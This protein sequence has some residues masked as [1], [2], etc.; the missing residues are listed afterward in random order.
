MTDTQAAV[1]PATTKT[2]TV[3]GDRVPRKLAALAGDGG[4]DVVELQLIG[5]DT[6]VRVRVV[7]GTVQVT[8]GDDA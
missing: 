5:V 8:E 2:V 7:D 6:S 4:C 3:S 1:R